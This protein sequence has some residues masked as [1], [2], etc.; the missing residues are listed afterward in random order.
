MYMWGSASDHKLGLGKNIN[1]QD[2]PLLAEWKADKTGF[3][4]E[5]G[6]PAVRYQLS[7]ID[8]AKRANLTKDTAVLSQIKTIGWGDS[9]CVMLDMKGRLFSMGSSV[10]GRLG[11]SDK[12]IPDLVK[13]PTQITF[14]LPKPSFQS[15][16]IHLTTGI[17]HSLAVTRSGDLY[18]WGE[19][20]M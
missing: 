6:K 17:S 8:Q 7:F 12:E 18:S 5:T 9:H 3:Y 19:G 20:S 16:I 14:G 1:T 11:L 15:K 2:E 10:C 4:T 13:Q